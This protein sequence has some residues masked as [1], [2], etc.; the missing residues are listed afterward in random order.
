MSID[1][2]RRRLASMSDRIEH[3]EAIDYQKEGQLLM[4]DAVDDQLHYVEE[5]FSR[6]K[7]AD[8]RLASHVGK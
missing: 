8:E 6:L 1:A 2:F 7:Q 4:L 3:D 5:A